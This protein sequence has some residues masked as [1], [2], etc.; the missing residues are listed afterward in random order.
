MSGETTTFL[1]TACAAGVSEKQPVRSS[2]RG[3][4]LGVSPL[5][6]GECSRNLERVISYSDTF[7]EN[8]SLFTNFFAYFRATPW[9]KC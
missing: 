6:R 2:F 5:T 8:F 3:F 9:G 1:K 4:K 7:S